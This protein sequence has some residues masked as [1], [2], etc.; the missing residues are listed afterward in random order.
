MGATPQGGTSDNAAEKAGQYGFTYKRSTRSYY[1]VQIL[2][3]LYCT[4]L[5]DDT[6]D[7][8]YIHCVHV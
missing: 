5:R 2:Y 7:C 3:V 8:T 4:K 1:P 6:Q